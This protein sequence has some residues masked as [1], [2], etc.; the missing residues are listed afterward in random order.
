MEPWLAQGF[1][2]T[3]QIYNVNCDFRGLALGSDAMI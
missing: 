2:Y 1:I 3:K